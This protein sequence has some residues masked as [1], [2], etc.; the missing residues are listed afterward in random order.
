MLNLMM[1]KMKKLRE[2]FIL[3][4]FISPLAYA[5]LQPYFSFD[6]YV[7][8]GL[9]LTETNEH[10]DEMD[11]YAL[12]ASDL[13]FAIHGKVVLSITD[14]TN[15]SKFNSQISCLGKIAGFPKE[16]DI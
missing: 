13:Q 9:C 16:S 14:K 4:L 5:T 7:T 3:S 6:R 8:E 1:R 12:E 10:F 11:R 15:D 2:L